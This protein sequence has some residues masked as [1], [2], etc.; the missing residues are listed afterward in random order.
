VKPNNQPQHHRNQRRGD[1]QSAESD[2]L[3]LAG[4]PLTDQTDRTNGQQKDRGGLRHDA[5]GI[6]SNRVYRGAS[7]SVSGRDAKV[8]DQVAMPPGFSVH[9]LTTNLFVVVFTWPMICGPSK[10]TNATS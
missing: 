8:G 6:E 5:N 9:E 4:L 7:C 10:S 1:E 2:L 3:A